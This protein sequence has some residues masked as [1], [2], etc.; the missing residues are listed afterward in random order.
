M[1]DIDLSC[2]EC[3]T[4]KKDI[5]GESMDDYGLCGRMISVWVN[6]PMYK[7]PAYQGLRLSLQRTGLCIRV[8]RFWSG[9]GNV[10]C[11]SWALI[12]FY[13]NIHNN[14]NHILHTGDTQDKTVRICKLGRD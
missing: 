2:V 10:V 8:S 12:I 3:R 9:N 14:S 7:C 1:I 6:P 13:W 4:G 5:E 11:L